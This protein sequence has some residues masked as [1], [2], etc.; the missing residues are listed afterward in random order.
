MLK[1]IKLSYVLKLCNS[2]ILT[3]AFK[4]SALKVTQRTTAVYNY[5]STD[6]CYFFFF[7]SPIFFFTFP[8]SNFSH[9]LTT[10]FQSIY[11]FTHSHP[12][13]FIFLAF[14]S[15]TNI[16]ILTSSHF[17]QSAAGRYQSLTKARVSQLIEWR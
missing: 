9:P 13:H 4:G 17:L 10:P 11:S 6:I 7:S 15:Y 5:R 2:P 3:F 14:P 12:R 16:F 8:Q 1:P